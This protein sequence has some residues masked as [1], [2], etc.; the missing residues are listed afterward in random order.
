MEVWT[1]QPGLQVFTG[2]NVGTT[3]GDLGIRHMLS[4]LVD[5]IPRRSWHLVA[6]QGLRMEAVRGHLLGTTAVARW[7][8]HLMDL[9]SPTL[10]PTDSR[11]WI[12]LVLF[13]TE[14]PHICINLGS[15]NVYN[16]YIHIYNW[17]KLQFWRV[18][19]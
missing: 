7:S 13:G 1:D 14:P 17:H 11:I 5:V 8:L 6:W 18:P 9:L 16:I 2:S 3:G 19:F 12:R 15:V 10:G 4:S